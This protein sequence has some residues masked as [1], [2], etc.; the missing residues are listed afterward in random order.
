VLYGGEKYFLSCENALKSC[1]VSSSNVA[2]SE[3]RLCNGEMH[4]IVT[5]DCKKSVDKNLCHTVLW[6]DESETFKMGEE[7]GNTNQKLDRWMVT[8]ANENASWL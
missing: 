2:S 1:S 8:A 3:S 4:I 5:K 6:Q 7:V